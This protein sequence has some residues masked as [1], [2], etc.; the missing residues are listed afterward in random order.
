[1]KIYPAMFAVCQLSGVCS[2]YNAVLLTYRQ[3][4]WRWVPM[5]RHRA[6]M[7]AKSVHLRWS[8]GLS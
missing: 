6:G 1:M 2:Q 4:L 5:W 3:R 8:Q 7:S